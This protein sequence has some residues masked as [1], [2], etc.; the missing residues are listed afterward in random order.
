[1]QHSY[2]WQPHLPFFPVDLPFSNWAER[3]HY[4]YQ[5][6]PIVQVGPHSWALDNRVATRWLSHV[7]F[8]SN[9]I[10]HWRNNLT[11]APMTVDY[12]PD[13][14]QQDITRHFD[15]EEKARR[16]CWFYRTLIFCMFAEFSFITAVRPNWRGQLATFCQENNLS[17]E[18]EWLNTVD[19]V[20]CDFRHTKRAGVIINVAT[21][22]LWPFLRRY[23]ENGVPVLMEVGSVTFR[24]KDQ[25]P[26]RLPLIQI[27]NA[28][29][30]RYDNI[31][32]DW[33]T[34]AE[35][36][37]R[38]KDFLRK[39]YGHRLGSAPAP[40]LS[41]S[42]PVVEE[43]GGD[44]HKWAPTTPW[45][46]PYTQETIDCI[47]VR[48]PAPANPRRVADHIGWIEF[49]DR[50]REVN[51]KR[52]I[53]ET[54]VE[55]QKRES[56]IRDSLKINQLHSCG[57]SKKSE[58]YKWVEEEPQ[59]G[60]VPMR[61]YLGPIWRRV[62]VNR[63]EVEEIWDDYLP[64]QR[65]Y[66]SFHNQWDLHRLFDVNA[67][68]PQQ[69]YDDN[70][71]DSIGDATHIDQIHI[72]Y[73]DQIAL[74][75]VGDA[76]SAVQLLSSQ[77]AFIAPKNLGDWSFFCLGLKCSRP[78][79]TSSSYRHT[80][81]LIGYIV[82]EHEKTT[83]IYE[84]L[85]EYVSY[86]VERD[87][88]NPRLA[89]LSDLQPTHPSPID[90]GNAA[91]YI[92][93]VTVSSNATGVPSKI[94]YI[95]TPKHESSS[96]EHGWILVVFEAITVL[97]IVR[98]L[99]ANSSMEDLVRHLVR[100]G[101]QFR[102]L[103]PATQVIPDDILKLNEAPVDFT[104]IPPMDRDVQLT[105]ADYT[106]YVELRQKIISSPHG[107]AAF[108]MGGIL[109]RLAMESKENF[110]DVINEIMDGPSELG[111]TRGEYLFVEGFRFY[112]LVVT[113]TVADT[114]DRKSTR[115]NSSHS[116]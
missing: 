88:Q 58:V 67:R 24:D 92:R 18:E 15:A 39:S 49:L 111:P 42:R 72:A 56:R 115:L 116:S 55:K 37:E 36:L 75:P 114:L 47:Q 93:R 44:V 17:L 66:D 113:Q 91:L 20:L 59:A 97:Q 68:P 27:T 7:N 103:V 102:T 109:W 22:Q 63:A 73:L 54:P 106:R 2:R 21:T 52:E 12:V 10:V 9:I 8:F 81:A 78:L 95:L 57:P 84:Y 45:V 14:R 70:D 79:E 26:P 108:R 35:L 80:S 30:H 112:D 89:V 46:N 4:K 19:N 34:Q 43:L 61:D 110:D 105:S 6:L 31:P 90:L 50:R 100:H 32:S 86:I 94:G 87:F 11:Y 71:E 85:Q 13:I 98:N 99:W 107:R 51:R 53:S 40:P 60:E 65:L 74:A 1:M 41:L 83:A 104:T 96:A 77:I 48:D 16:F 5:T 33:P 25:W 29:A 38:T 64:S 69:D 62:R 82:D 28:T 3:Y 76:Y 101:I 23:H